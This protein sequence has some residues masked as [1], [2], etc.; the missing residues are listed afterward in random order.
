VVLHNTT[1]MFAATNV[2]LPP[3][4][5]ATAY[6]KKAAGGS[7][8]TA[9]LMG[10][11]AKLIVQLGEI[12]PRGDTFETDSWAPVI[13]G[14]GLRRSIID[15]IIDGHVAPGVALLAGSNRDEGTIFMGLTPSLRCNATAAEFGKWADAFYGPALGSAI[16]SLYSTLRTPVPKCHDGHHGAAARGEDYYMDG[17][18]ERTTTVRGLHG[19]DYMDAGGEDYYMAAMRS[20]GDY[21]ITC[22]VRQAAQQMNSRGHRV[23]VYY[24]AHTPAYSAN[25]EHLDSLGAFHGAE[26]PFVFGYQPELRTSAELSLSRTMGCYWRN[27]LHTADPNIPPAHGPPCRVPHQPIDWPS[28]ER[29]EEATMILDVPPTGSAVERSLKQ[30]QCDAF[31]AG[32][33]GTLSKYTQ[34]EKTKT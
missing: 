33:P 5:N 8:G 19:E 16:P 7:K 23:H 15:S 2:G 11:D 29:G 26:V 20:A 12:V 13:D 21:A 18:M 28:F 9:C 3:G 4:E 22:R 27:F 25:Y 10:A 31:F 1:T 6:L 34:V 14:V 17:D 32:Q 30:Q 24:F